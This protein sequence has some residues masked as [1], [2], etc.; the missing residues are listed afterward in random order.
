MVERLANPFAAE[1]V[2]APEQHYFEAPLVGISKEL[3]KPRSLGRAAA[4]LVTALPIDC[5]AHPLGEGAQLQELVV[6]GLALVA[7]RHASINGGGGHATKIN[8]GELLERA[9]CFKEMCNHTVIFQR[10][11]KSFPT[12]ESYESYQFQRC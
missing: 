4:F 2:Q 3:L 1:A 10:N 6:D 9:S 8:G 7:G 12:N 5:V 11:L